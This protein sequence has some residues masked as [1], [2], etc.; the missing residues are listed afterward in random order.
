MCSDYENSEDYIL[1]IFLINQ[2]ML[3]INPDNFL[4]DKALLGTSN[5]YADRFFFNTVSFLLVFWQV[6][7]GEKFQETSINT[8]DTGIW[9]NCLR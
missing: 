5:A 3:Y 8:P 6:K 2:M 9:G 1:I 4:F 7:P